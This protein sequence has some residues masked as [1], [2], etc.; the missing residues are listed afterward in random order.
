MKRFLSLALILVVSVSSFGQR[1]G[2][3][4]QAIKYSMDIDMDVEK[5]QF[6][7]K[8]DIQYYNNSP[9]TL[10]QLYFH[11]YFNAFAPESM[12]DKRSQDLPDPDG[13]ISKR[14]GNLSPEEIGYHKIKT[15]E[16]DGTSPSYNV[17]GTLMRIDLQKPIPPGESS[18]IKLTFDSQVPKQ[19]RRS[20]RDNSETVDYTMTQWYPKMAEYS[21]RGW[22]T[23]QYV[24][25]EFFGVFGT[26]DVRITIDS[27]YVLGGTGTITNACDLDKAVAEA[28]CPDKIKKQKG[29]TQ[30]WHFH[31]ENVHDFA[32]AADDEFFVEHV[33]TEKGI[34][35]YFLRLEDSDEKSWTAMKAYTQR[36]IKEM[37]AEF[38]QYPYPQF[39][40]I[41][42]GD[43][44]MEYPMCTMILGNGGKDN[45]GGFIALMIHEAG[46]NW[47]YGILGFDEQR[48]AWMDEGFTTYAE[49]VLINEFFM[50]G[51]RA[52][53]HSG[54]YKAYRRLVTND[55]QEPM[56]T[57]ADHFTRNRAYS[58]SSYSMGNLYLAQLEYLVGKDILRASLREF[59]NTWKFS[60]PGP[61][62]LLRIV[63]RRSGMQLHWF[64]DLWIGTTQ[65]IDYSIQGVKSF[66]RDATT[67]QLKRED[68]FPMPLEIRI[69]LKGTGDQIMVYVPTDLTI[70]PKSG[71][72][73]YAETWPWTSRDREVT[74][75]FPYTDI[76]KIEIDPNGW[77]AD[78]DPDNQ[79]W[80][81]NATEEKKE[82][83]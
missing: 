78:I 31:A 10:R 20:G 80:D 66:G 58:I 6:T 36:F 15:L 70:V 34:D 4:Q 39:S 59:F 9:D 41:Q 45:L 81:S 64:S 30:T 71:S 32:W 83:E 16:V 72:F 55:W 8:Q 60:H 43:G 56:T 68:E 18:N 74:I 52:N 51:K 22:H 82:E 14:I 44:G 11:L 75:P 33:E 69:T 35:L 28:Y 48:Y 76:D 46:H 12:M 67:L 3:W 1:Q 23:Q 13:R 61:D 62:D 17:Y 73:T 26:F 29:K 53:P 63:E 37:S 38:G 27:D 40:V 7:G 77:M 49:N 54:S 2:Y 57:P 19:V 21:E 79:V 5:H 50:D 42:G 24:N 25:R 47:Y 65:R